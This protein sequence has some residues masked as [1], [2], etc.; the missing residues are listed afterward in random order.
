MSSTTL[1]SG[2]DV[3]MSENTKLA[4]SLLIPPAVL[5]GLIF[6]FMV[7][8]TLAS[9]VFSKLNLTLMDMVFLVAGFIFPGAALTAGVNG[10]SKKTDTFVNLWVVVVSVV[11]LVLMT[12]NI[13]LF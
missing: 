8:S 9:Y 13:F 7:D 5:W 4:L 3:T 1:P 10:L 2:K 12:M 11:M 6:L